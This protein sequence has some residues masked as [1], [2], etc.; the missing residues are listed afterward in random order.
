MKWRRAISLPPLS[1]LCGS[2][3]RVQKVDADGHPM[4]DAAGNPIYETHEGAHSADVGYDAEAN[5][6]G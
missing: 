3:D 4:F 6:S 1:P 2:I 5:F